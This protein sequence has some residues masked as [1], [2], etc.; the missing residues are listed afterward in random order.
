MSFALR[1][2]RLVTAV[3]VGAAFAVLCGLG[4]WQISRL[5]WK[6]GLIE[7]IE[8]RLAAPA[9]PLPSGS[10]VPDDWQYRHVTVAGTFQH[11]REIHLYGANTR[12]VPGFLI[13]TPLIRPDAPTVL[14][15]RG[16][17]P[18]DHKDPATRS[19]GQVAGPV[20]ITGIVHLPWPR[21]TFVGDNMP[22]ENMW[23][24]GDIDAMA[25]HLGLDRYAPVFVDADATQNPGGLP[26]GGQTRVKLPNDH[27]Q[28][29]L[30]WFGL[31]LALAVMFVYAHARREESDLNA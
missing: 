8:T 14:V 29:A 15:S 2:P 22:A 30:T 26:E 21:R 3:A 11:S 7:R 27:L 23:F 16:W 19:Q 9:V 4:T 17:V 13:I 6:L 10:I 31:A 24:Y 5:Q 28:Y 18:R 1:R 12:G 25:R 20:R